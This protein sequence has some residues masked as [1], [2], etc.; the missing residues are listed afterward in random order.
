M[1]QP[2]QNMPVCRDCGGFT[3][4]AVTTGT[5]NRDGSRTTLHIDCRTCNGTARIALASEQEVK[6]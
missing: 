2:V 4:V 3:T 6:A 5:R 1:P